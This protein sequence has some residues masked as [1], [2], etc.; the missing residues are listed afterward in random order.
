MTLIGRSAPSTA[1]RLRRLRKHLAN[2]EHMRRAR[3]ARKLCCVGVDLPLEAGACGR[4]VRAESQ[5]CVHCARRRW[6][7]LNHALNDVE[8]AITAILEVDT[9]ANRSHDDTPDHVPAVIP[10]LDELTDLGDPCLRW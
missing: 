5:R 3:E 2:R 1:E 4:M 10:T 7:L 8:L 6:W 9:A